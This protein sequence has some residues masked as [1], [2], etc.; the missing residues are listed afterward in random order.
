MPP[1]LQYTVL[2]N[3]GHHI[4]KEHPE[5]LIKAIKDMIERLK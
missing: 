2:E 5:I 3:S 4:T 1:G